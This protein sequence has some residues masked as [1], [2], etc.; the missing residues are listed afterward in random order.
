MSEE[1]KDRVDPRILLQTFYRNEAA[2]ALPMKKADSMIRFLTAWFTAE[3]TW[4]PPSTVHVDTGWM[5]LWEYSNFD[6][7]SIAHAAGLTTVSALSLMHKAKQ[8]KMILPTGEVQPAV[9]RWLNMYATEHMAKMGKEVAKLQIAQLFAEEK[10]IKAEDRAR[11]R[12]QEQKSL[13]V[14]GDDDFQA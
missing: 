2:I 6:I 4:D 7:Y 8:L 3:T 9:E 10:R 5:E 12:N 1:N 14:G 11:K 13:P